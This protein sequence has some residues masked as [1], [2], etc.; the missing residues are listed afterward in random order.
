[1]REHCTGFVP[2]CKRNVRVLSTGTKREIN[3]RLRFQPRGDGMG[4]KNERWSP[5]PAEKVPIIALVGARRA[6][7]RCVHGAIRRGRRARSAA[8]TRHRE[9]ERSTPCPAEKWVVVTSNPPITKFAKQP[10]AKVG[11]ARE[12]EHCRRLAATKRSQPYPQR[13]LSTEDCMNKYRTCQ[14]TA[15]VTVFRFESL[16]GLMSRPIPFDFRPC[17]ISCSRTAERH[18]S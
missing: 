17:S 12:Q 3:K 2:V 8:P 14:V 10:Y 18:G 7:P 11:R 16:P 4:S 15:R 9:S 1:M 6:R 5:C 13:Q